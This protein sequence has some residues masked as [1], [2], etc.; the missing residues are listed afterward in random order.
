MYIKYIISLFVCWIILFE[1]ISVNESGVFFGK[2]DEKEI[3]FILKV[4]SNIVFGS[5]SQNGYDKI[6]FSGF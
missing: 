4:E 3:C 2:V 5:Y 6:S 1:Q